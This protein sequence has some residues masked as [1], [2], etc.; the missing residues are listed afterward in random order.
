MLNL[1]CLPQKIMFFIFL[2][3]SLQIKAEPLRVGVND[4]LAA[5]LPVKTVEI[6]SALIASGLP[7][8]FQTLPPRRSLLSAARGDIAIEA[9]RTPTAVSRYTAL[10]KLEPAVDKQ[11]LW[12]AARTPRLCDINEE[13]RLLS[14]VVGVRG[15]RLYHQIYPDFKRYEVVNNLKAAAGMLAASRVD[16]ALFPAEF[17][18]WLE[19]VP[20]LDVHI[21]NKEP[22][23]SF[24]FHSYIHEKYRW[25]VPAIEASYRNVFAV[26]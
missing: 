5:H 16:F 25:A 15:V 18:T 12:L 3:L 8:D 24:I 6:K 17:I 10:I 20:N 14:T 26:E 21:C 4:L 7:M 13:G 23:I 1:K 9:Y 19:S 22:Y 2:A 11:E